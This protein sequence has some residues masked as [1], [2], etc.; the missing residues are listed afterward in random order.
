MGEEHH[1]R[2]KEVGQGLH[3][4]GCISSTSGWLDEGCNILEYGKNNGSFWTRELCVKQV[5]LSEL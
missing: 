5:R 4:S 3:V 2:K 1:L